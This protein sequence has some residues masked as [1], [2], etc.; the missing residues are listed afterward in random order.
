MSL[1][2]QINLAQQLAQ[3]NA[4]LAQQAA[5]AINSNVVTI[6]T[7]A[8]IKANMLQVLPTYR[9]CLASW[10]GDNII[11]AELEGYLKSEAANTAIQ[12]TYNRFGIIPVN[13]GSPGR[14]NQC[15]AYVVN[16]Y[17]FCLSIKYYLRYVNMDLNNNNNCKQIKAQLDALEI[18][19]LNADKQF[20]TDQNNYRHSATSL[21]LTDLQSTLLAAY[22]SLS[23]ATVINQVKQTETLQAIS[24]ATA[25]SEAAN[26]GGGSNNLIYIIAAVAIMVVLFKIFK[27]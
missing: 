25:E 9:E 2:L 13:P 26:N 17:N 12:Y 15:S 22:G 21:V 16:V 7:V 5:S 20:V 6:K 1:N 24:A 14:Y 27:S 10:L 18:E 19:K 4:Q 3:Q 23:C 8:D 11:Y